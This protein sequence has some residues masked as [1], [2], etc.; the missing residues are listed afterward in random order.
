MGEPKINFQV[1][2]CE[3]FDIKNVLQVYIHIYAKCF[4]LRIFTRELFAGRPSGVLTTSMRI[5][6]RFISII[7]FVENVC[8]Q[9]KV[10]TLCKIFSCSTVVMDVCKHFSTHEGACEYSV[11]L[12]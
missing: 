9:E 1:V 3:L 2:E 7:D 8:N 10:C 12:E 5:E 6:N 11:Q 4:G